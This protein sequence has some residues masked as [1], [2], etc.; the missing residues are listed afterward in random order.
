MQPETD[1]PRTDTIDGNTAVA[2]VAYRVNDVCAMN[3]IWATA[4][5]GWKSGATA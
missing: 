2:H 5:P 3:D 4:P 1:T